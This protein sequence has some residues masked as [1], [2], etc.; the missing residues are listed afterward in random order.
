MNAQPDPAVTFDVLDLEEVILEPLRIA[1]RTRLFGPQVISDSQLS[2]SSEGITTTTEVG[3]KEMLTFPENETVFV[4]GLGAGSP[5]YLTTAE[6]ST[7][8][9][10]GGGYPTPEAGGPPMGGEKKDVR[11]PGRAR[12]GG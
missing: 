8:D 4:C 11:V 1:T 5:V 12:A 3:F 9:G 7:D 2:T 6:S 10:R